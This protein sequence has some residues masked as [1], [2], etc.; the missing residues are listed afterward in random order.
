MDQE[1]IISAVLKNGGSFEKWLAPFFATL[2]LLLVFATVLIVMSL[3]KR[4]RR[5]IRETDAD[6]YRGVVDSEEMLAFNSRTSQ[7]NDLNEDFNSPITFVDSN[8]DE[9]V[10]DY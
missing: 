10:A 8:I 3:K 9:L 1:D 7:Q 5:N 2:G 6:R 4:A